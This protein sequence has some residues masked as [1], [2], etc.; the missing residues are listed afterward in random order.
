MESNG[1]IYYYEND[2]IYKI[3]L[4]DKNI[5]LLIT[6]SK[7]NQIEKIISDKDETIVEIEDNLVGTIKGGKHEKK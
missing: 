5:R 3:L 7:Y 6:C 2:E 1:S 4:K